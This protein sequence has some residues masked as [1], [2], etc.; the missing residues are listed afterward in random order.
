[1]GEVLEFRRMR[2]L[3][4]VRPPLPTGVLS[5]RDGTPCPP[6]SIATC[7]GDLCREVRSW[8]VES[9]NATGTRRSYQTP[10]L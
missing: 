4:E 10:I 5:R 6:H 9:D 3:R 2:K 1:V 7:E 8:L